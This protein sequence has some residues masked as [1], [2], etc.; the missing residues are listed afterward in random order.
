MPPTSKPSSKRAAAHT[1]PAVNEN[2]SSKSARRDED[3]D[4]GMLPEDVA[5]QMFA[6]N[7][8]KPVPEV[9]HSSG[10]SGTVNIEGVVTRAAKM[11]V[12]G[13]AG[14]VPKVQVTVLATKIFASG[15][16]PSVISTNIDGIAF[17]MPTRQMEAS[18][19]EIAKDPNAKGPVFI[20]IEDA[21]SHSNYLGTISA[22]FYTEAGGGGKAAS[23]SPKVAEIA[24]V[25][26][27]VPGVKVLVTG[28]TCSF[29]KGAGSTTLY[30]NAK[31]IQP[32]HGA[33]S[34]GDAACNVIANLTQ[35]NAQQTSAFL[36]S[37]T[38][39]GFFDTVYNEP[40][41]AE[42]AEVFKVK[43]N[44]FPESA[45]A[46][47]EQLSTMYASVNEGVSAAL[48]AHAQRIKDI[49]GEDAAQGASLFHTPIQKDCMTSYVVPIVQKGTVPGSPIHGLAADLFD[50][51]KRDSLPPTFADAKVVGVQYRGNLAQVDYRLSFVG[52]KDLAIAAINDGK[53]PVIQIE[54]ATASVKLSKRSVGPELVGSIVDKKIEMA[55][56][57]LMPFMDH[58]SIAFVF[59]RPFTSNTVDGHFTSTAGFDI[60]SAI[61]RVGI[62]VSQ[63]YLDKSMLGG[64]GVLIHKNADDANLIEPMAGIAPAPS[65]SKNGYQAVSEGSFDFDSLKPPDE[66]ETKFFVIY[67]GCGH[68]VVNKTSITTNPDDGEA[69]IDD[70]AASMRE[71]GD[72][73]AFLKEDVLVYAVAV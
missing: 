37:S 57:E 32:L 34:P 29:G 72:L 13:K 8:S 30:T 28:V 63:K 22:S 46:K 3:S 53:N 20:D 33:I 71:D 69:H 11:M 38:V 56:M 25:E 70:I 59:P 54:N 61:K 35:T 18:P 21:N 16:N 50:P 41:L 23:K 6:A 17:G 5:K 64:R 66:K 15:N 9:K 43:W 31:K 52:D 65:L 39:G 1:E 7:A 73:K 48:A 42:Q 2:E 58:A 19:E 44:D 4:V 68:N 14:M 26:A 45:R 67:S 55:L 36:L 51:K 27:C 47:C 12:Q 10:G 49:K 24:S 40:H 60:T 62:I